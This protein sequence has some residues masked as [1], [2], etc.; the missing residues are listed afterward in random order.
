MRPSMYRRGFGRGGSQSKYSDKCEVWHEELGKYRVIK[1]YSAQEV[2]DRADEILEKWQ[3]QWQRKLDR[4]ERQEIALEKKNYKAK[5][6]QRAALYTDEENQ[7]TKNLV[8]L[9]S[10]PSSFNITCYWEK[11]YD[12]NSFTKII[13]EFPVDDR[14]PKPQNEDAKYI[15]KIY[16]F[17]KIFKS[18]IE[19]KKNH[20]LDA[21]NKDLSKWKE[22]ERSYKQN[23]LYKTNAITDWEEEKSLFEQEQKHFNM[24]IDLKKDAFNRASE[25]EVVRYVES[26]IEDYS[27]PESFPSNFD[28]EYHE[29]NKTLSINFQMPDKVDLPCTVDVKYVMS[30][31]EFKSKKMLVKDVNKLYNQVLT[32][33]PVRIVKDIIKEEKCPPIS[34]IVFNGMIGKNLDINAHRIIYWKTNMVNALKTPLLIID[35][36]MNC[37]ENSSW[38]LNEK[39]HLC[40]YVVSKT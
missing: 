13:P 26:I 23:L 39:L 36:E 10:T 11:K 19:N 20:M 22:N 17:D 7:K 6:K 38:V 29:I 15:P 3:E 24:N 35:E 33:I 5:Q 1:G 12:R 18:R 27:W 9:L 16:W 34:N 14:Y 4:L 40:K 31:D 28:V 32:T 8:K 37:P 30:K 25:C 21:F 2:S